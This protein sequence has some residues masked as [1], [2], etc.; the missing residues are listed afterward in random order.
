MVKPIRSKTIF[1]AGLAFAV[2]QLFVPVL[3]PL[4][5]MQLRSSARLFLGICIVLLAFPL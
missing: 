4:Y 2:F 1:W 5:D 3:V